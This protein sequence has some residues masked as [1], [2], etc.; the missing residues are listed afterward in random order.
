MGGESRD[1]PKNGAVDGCVRYGSVRGSGWVV[2]SA[3]LSVFP[4]LA[5][6]T[7]S[8]VL[9]GWRE[10][11]VAE[12]HGPYLASP[13][14]RARG[15]QNSTGARAI[16]QEGLALAFALTPTPPR[17]G[18]PCGSERG[19]MRE[20]CTSGQD[21]SINNAHAAQEERESASTSPRSIPAVTV[22]GQSSLARVSRLPGT[23]PPLR[24]S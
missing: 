7:L 22:R 6:A 9:G 19:G 17:N 23:K 10:T 16:R 8:A 12:W 21:A 11:I 15:A 4:A 3:S 2:V 1:G 24:R 14:L 20:P 13:L 18:A 5:P